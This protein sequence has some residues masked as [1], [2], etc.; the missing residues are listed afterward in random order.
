MKNSASTFHFP[1]AI[2]TVLTRIKGSQIGLEAV[3]ESQG[4]G[5]CVEVKSLSR[6]LNFR[7][8]LIPLRKTFRQVVKFLTARL[9]VVKEKHLTVKAK[10][11]KKKVR[12]LFL[13]FSPKLLS[14]P[15]RLQ[16]FCIFQL[17]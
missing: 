12:I 3:T 16:C 1:S 9:S 5:S 15:H 14:K 4:D 17:L 10:K 2:P 7:R 6:E 8:N 11:K 13:V